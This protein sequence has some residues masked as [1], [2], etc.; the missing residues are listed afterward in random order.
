MVCTIEE[1][2]SAHNILPKDCKV[3][4]A[5][6][7]GPDS[8]ALLHFFLQLRDKQNL[9]IMA[10]HVH[11]GLRDKTADADEQFVKRWCELRDIPCFT[12][13]INVRKAVKEKSGNVQEEA[14]RLRYDY[15]RAL[16]ERH[17]IAFLA[18]GH[19][20]DDQMETMLMKQAEGRAV[21]GELG[22]AFTRMFGSG[23]LIRP[24]LWVT[25]NEI[26]TYCKKHSIEYRVD[27]SN[28]SEKYTRN[29]FRQYVLPFLKKENPS[30]HLHF[31][32]Y[33]DWLSAE[34]EYIIN[35]AKSAIDQFIESRDDISVT[36]HISG[37][38]SLPYPL[39]RRGIPLVLNYL[40]QHKVPELS[41]L[42]IDQ[43]LTLI[44]QE[45]PSFSIDWPGGVKVSRN[46]GLLTFSLG[47]GEN[48]WV[49]PQ[50]I[51]L[52]LSGQVSFHHFSFETEKYDRNKETADNKNTLVLKENEI[53]LPLTIRTTEPGD[54]INPLG[55]RGRKKVSRLFIDS[56]IPREERGHWP[57]LTDANGKI[58]WVPLL[59]KSSF[60][61]PSPKTDDRL[62]I[63]RCKKNKIS[64]K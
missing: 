25:K 36:I 55:M 49:Q 2:L 47:A 62:I 53:C 39:Q 20:A 15:L 19:H 54:R 45:N 60:H 8:M 14:R 17:G 50:N 44:Q 59:R 42:H 23:R 56:K 43:L 33:M 34:R 13:K 7:G 4:V 5:V 31:Q 64:F 3:L 58:L 6:S 38:R 52:P 41:V 1:Q 57:V 12:T 51:H 29:R 10:A 21:L 48:K 22:M 9:Q 24:L 37:F 26:I 16:M 30:V 61:V 35:E 28:H 11:H 27:E 18:T 63:I 46:Y 32:E 40:Y